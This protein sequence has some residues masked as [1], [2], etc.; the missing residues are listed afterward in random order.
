MIEGDIVGYTREYINMFDGAKISD[1][2]VIIKDTIL[3]EVVLIKDKDDKTEFTK[4]NINKGWLYVVEEKKH[5]EKSNELYIV[6]EFEGV[7]SI[8]KTCV[9]TVRID[10]NDKKLYIS[11]DISMRKST[12]LIFDAYKK[13]DELRKYRNPIKY[14]F[15]LGE[16]WK[17]GWRN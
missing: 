6:K 3:G 17:I 14:G 5:E 1:R 15:E 16:G 9:T 8:V 13:D 12:D 2:F 4:K 11:P 10:F 7:F